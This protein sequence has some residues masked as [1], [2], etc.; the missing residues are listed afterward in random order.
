MTRQK[1]PVLDAAELERESREGMAYGGRSLMDVDPG[2]LRASSKKL[3]AGITESMMVALRWLGTR[4]EGIFRRDDRL[5]A[6]GEISRAMR[7]TWERLRDRGFL[8]QTQRGGL[9]V[10]ESGHGLIRLY[11]P[12]QEELPGDGRHR[13]GTGRV[14]RHDGAE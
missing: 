10:N 11:P 8:D 12:P 6:S 4:G 1:P 3:P 7:G 5:L 2:L 13:D 14:F 9:R